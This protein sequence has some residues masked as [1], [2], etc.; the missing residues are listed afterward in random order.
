MNSD[1]LNRFLVARNQIIRDDFPGLNDMQLKAVMATEG[2]LL[3][4]AGAGSGKTTILIQR[5]ANLIKYGRASDSNDIPEYIDE[6]DVAFLERFIKSPD[7]AER[8]AAEKLC[9]LDPVSPWSV[10]AITFTNKAAEELKNR[11]TSKLGDRALD[12][13]ASTFH[14]ACLRILRR[15]IER[16]GYSRSFTIYDTQDSERVMKGVIADLNLE[17]KTFT[18]KLVLKYISTA[19]D[20]MVMPSEYEEAFSENSS[21]INSRISKAYAEY[22]RRLKDA[23]ALDFDDII[24]CAVTLLL[25]HDDVREHYQ[26][27]FKYV[28]IDEYQDTNNLQY[29]L[30]RTLAG[31]WKNLCVVGDDDQSIYRFRG[32]SVENILSFENR[33]NSCRTI[34]LEQN[35]R[36]TQ[37]ILMAANGVIE[38]NDGRKGKTLWTSN[39]E[40]NKISV[41]EAEDDNDESQQI[42]K[43]V[44]E[45]YAKGG[46]FR[47]FAVLYRMNAQSNR[48]E[49]AFKRN[50]IPYRII[51]GIRFFDRAEIKDM[52]AYLHVIHNTTDNLR[53]SRIINVPTRGI[54]NKSLETTEYI[55]H[56]INSS[57]FDVVSSASNYDQLSRVASRLH[58][59]AD[60]ILDLKVKSESLPL[61]DFYD[62][63]LS[64]TG[65]LKSLQDR[66]PNEP[67]VVTR[68]ENVL[69]LKS[70]IIQYTEQA[71]EPSL[72]GFLDEVSLFTDIERYDSEA[73]AVVMMTIHS[74]KGLEFP[75]VFLV[76][77]EEGVFPSLRSASSREELE[78][79]RRLCYVGITRARETLHITHALRRMLFGQTSYNRVS[80]FINEIPDECLEQRKP[81]PATKRRSVSF[82][83][84]YRPNTQQSSAALPDL[85]IGDTIEHTAFGTGL[86]LAIKPMGNDALIEIAFDKG[87]KR[88][89]LKAASKYIEKILQ[90]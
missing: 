65:Y 56:S 6:A 72:G 81:E 40:G 55:A 87:T 34:K 17:N 33:N 86:L 60:M 59:F 53:L 15:D 43:K 79:E 20:K 3:V 89:M 38:N 52:L 39:N 4:L 5:I 83:P 80:R 71:D 63:V 78:E 35:Y 61:A 30:A 50:A 49:D 67:E 76:G 14:S 62:E 24:L 36:S 85:R 58:A 26:K 37:N 74:A 54:G 21:F 8:E 66:E 82:E 16:L 29:I 84:T 75:T 64:R 32:A 73:D 51:G 2:P 7:P 9:A 77:L 18:P 12:V 46:K 23:N 25:Q 27:K 1:M 28:L 45:G 48:I 41:Y 22:Q 47:D 11:L 10:I 42:A 90:T 44:M 19:K 69:E 13:W 31:Y 70:N 57:L 68:I 88:L